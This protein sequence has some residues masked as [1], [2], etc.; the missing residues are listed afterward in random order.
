[1]KSNKKLKEIVRVISKKISPE[2]IYLFGS[3]INNKGISENTDYD[4]FVIKKTKASKYKRMLDIYKLFNARDFSMDVVVYTPE[5]VNLWKDVS[6]SF[7]SHI[8]ETG[9]LVYEK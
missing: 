6:S 7:V 4:I 9:K 2:K 1:M 3:R 5:E 8:L